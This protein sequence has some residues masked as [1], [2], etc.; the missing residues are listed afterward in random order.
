MGM[1]F[2]EAIENMKK[3]KRLPEEAGT[4]RSSTSS[5]L[6]ESLTRPPRVRLSTV[7]MMQLGIKRLRLLGHLECRWAGWHLRRICWQ[8]I[9]NWLNKCKST[10]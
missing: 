10:T 4:E 5:L 6:P 3:G 9:G 1:T 8:K 2:G 7:N